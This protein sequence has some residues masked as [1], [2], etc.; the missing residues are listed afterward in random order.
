MYV[1]QEHINNLKNQA[2]V[3]TKN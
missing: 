2:A 1:F 3:P